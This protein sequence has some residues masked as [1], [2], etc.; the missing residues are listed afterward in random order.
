MRYYIAD[1]HFY[2]KNLLTEMD[3]Q[4]RAP[5]V[6]FIF[7]GSQQTK[8]SSVGLFIPSAGLDDLPIGGAPEGFDVV[9]VLDDGLAFF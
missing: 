2:H 5:G 9:E 1:C 4:E 7:W 6:L 3:K 8:A